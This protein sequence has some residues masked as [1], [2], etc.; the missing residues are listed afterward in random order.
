MRPRG[1]AVLVPEST[2]RTLQAKLSPVESAAD[3]AWRKLRLSAC[4]AR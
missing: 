4:V 2:V 1:I 3:D